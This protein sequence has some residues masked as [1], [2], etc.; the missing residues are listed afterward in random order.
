MNDLVTPGVTTRL[1]R[2]QQMRQEGQT[3]FNSNQQPCVSSA[4]LTIS[5]S[6]ATTTSSTVE[7]PVTSAPVSSTLSQAQETA[8]STVITTAASAVLTNTTSSTSTI[9]SSDS[10]N[11]TDSK[12]EKAIEKSGDSTAAVVISDTTEGDEDEEGNVSVVG[13]AAG[14][15]GP[16]PCVVCRTV[17]EHH[18]QSRPLPKH[19]ATQYGLEVRILDLF[20]FC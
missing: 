3:N 1:Q 6:A 10:A 15:G 2:E 13:S 20:V 11:V 12:S 4:S 5:S 16:H 9:I 8:S 7:A 18:G 17:L 19:Q 14:T